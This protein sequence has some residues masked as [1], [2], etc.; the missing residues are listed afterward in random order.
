PEWPV[1]GPLIV[2][3]ASLILGALLLERAAAY[4][5]APDPAPPSF[6]RGA[7]ALAL[8]PASFRANAGGVRHLRPFL[9]RQTGRYSGLRVPLV[10]LHGE[11]DAVVGLDVHSR[12]LHREVPDSELIVLPGAGH[13]LPYAHPDE[14]AEAIEKALGRAG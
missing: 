13:L 9:R 4:S 7:V 11:G 14:V 10:I 5:F 1:V 3:T 8:R 2:E 12:R 6:A